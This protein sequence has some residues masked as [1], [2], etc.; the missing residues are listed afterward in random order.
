MIFLFRWSNLNEREYMDARWKE[1][2]W[3][4]VDTSDVAKNW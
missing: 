3:I 1:D 4:S 2:G